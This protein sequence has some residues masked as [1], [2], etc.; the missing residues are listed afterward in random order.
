M[1]KLKAF[2]KMNAKSFFKKFQNHKQQQ[3]NEKLYL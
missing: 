1:I 3:E 2:D